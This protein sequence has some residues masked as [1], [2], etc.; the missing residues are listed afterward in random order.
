[1]T[2]GLKGDTPV[3]EGFFRLLGDKE[4]FR[5]IFNK[6]PAYIPAAVGLG[7]ASQNKNGGSTPK[8]QVGDNVAAIAS[9]MEANEEDG[10][11]PPLGVVDHIRAL[12][13]KEGLCR[14]NTCV[15]TVKDFYTK[16]GIEAMPKD[17][18][19][20]REFLKNFE[21]YGFEEILD[22]KNLQPGDVLQYYYNE[23][24][25][26]IDAN[27]HLLNFPYHMGVYVNP[28]EYIGDGESEA[29]IQRKNMYTK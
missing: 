14:D 13:D 18:Y 27:Q 11:R 25:E 26:G 8:A 23:D 17:V 28:G 3:D 1:M 16:A 9:Q 29:P 20:N 19:N 10:G 5:K 21:E 15:Q 4:N 2:K 12:F 22:Q 6:L 7:A 24:T